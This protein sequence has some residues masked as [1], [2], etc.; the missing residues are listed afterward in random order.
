MRGGHRCCLAALG[1]RKVQ[2]AGEIRPADFADEVR[3]ATHDELFAGTGQADVEAFAGA[4]ERRRLVDHEHDGTALEPLEADDVAI[5][6]LVGI[7]DAVPVGG[8]AGLELRCQISHLK[9]K[10]VFPELY[11]LLG[12]QGFVGPFGCS[13]PHAEGVELA[14]VGQLVTAPQLAVMRSR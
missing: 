6:N 9:R 2:T 11:G 4:F 12:A 5:E 7:P 1:R 8:V 10:V 3:V 13:R 14:D